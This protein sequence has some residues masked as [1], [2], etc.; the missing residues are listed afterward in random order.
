MP[1]LKGCTARSTHKPG[2]HL[3]LPTTAKLGAVIASLSRALMAIHLTR[4]VML[5]ATGTLV[6]VRCW[7]E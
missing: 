3:T 2:A 4:I 7:M 1:F 5:N 6:A